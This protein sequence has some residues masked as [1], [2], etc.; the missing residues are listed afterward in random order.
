MPETKLTLVGVLRPLSRH[1]TPPW[2]DFAPN[3]T[4][5]EPI[6]LE[7]GG[8]G[9]RD[10]DF[11]PTGLPPTESGP[12]PKWITPFFPPP[13]TSSRPDAD[14]VQGYWWSLSGASARNSSTPVSV[15]GAIMQS[16]S[17]GQVTSGGRVPHSAGCQSES[18]GFW[19]LKASR[20]A[21]ALIRGRVAAT[22]AESFFADNSSPSKR[23]AGSGRSTHTSLSFFLTN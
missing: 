23:Q 18:G 13:S 6:E 9:E 10:V 14:G 22:A 2:L 11:T 4:R 1:A 7:E 21:R 3:R 12:C 15:A 19:R 20:W 8:G 5:L 16:L 17:G